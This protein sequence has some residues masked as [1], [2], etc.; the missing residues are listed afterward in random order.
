MTPT[1]PR[2]NSPSDAQASGS[3]DA[4][5]ARR[6]MDALAN[7]YS[8]YSKIRVGAALLSSDGRIFAGC[9]VENASFGLTMCA[10][11]TALAK[12]VSEGAREFET[13]AIATD[14]EKALMPCGACRQALYEFAPRLRILVIG[15]DGLLRETLLENLLP[16]AFGPADVTSGSADLPDR[17]TGVSPGRADDLAG[18][19]DVN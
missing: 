8:P 12:A 6:A 15:S 19:A 3:E 7:A 1:T 18:S 4:Q 17:P 5:L 14:G 2:R 11:R 9:N 16:E 10:E 13:M